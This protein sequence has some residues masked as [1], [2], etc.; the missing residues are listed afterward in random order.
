MIMFRLRRLALVLTIAFAALTAAS[1]IHTIAKGDSTM[2]LC[3][4]TA[5]TPLK[6]APS[7]EARAIFVLN[8]LQ[9]GDPTAAEIYISPTTCIQH[10]P[11]APDGREGVLAF[12]SNAT[13]LGATVNV[14]RVLV[15]GNFVALHSEYNFGGPM[16]GFDVFRFEDG[17]IVEHWD[18]LSP[19]TPPNPSKH[20]QTDG[21]VVVTDLDK[22]SQNCA[23]VVEFITKAL[24][25]PDPKLDITQYISPKTYIQHNPQVADGLAG[26]GEFMQSMAANKQV[27]SYSKIHFVVAQGNFV[28]VGSEGT[29][30]AAD[31]PTPTVY[32]DLFRLE[33]G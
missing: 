24:I 13:K 4:V 29:F 7:I 12:L 20:T 8:S 21:T 18:N 22:T 16:V 33:N 27:M 26:F 5:L 9:S 17:K 11:R 6:E 10:N 1:F 32:Y 19:K 25:T 23:K 3:D 14:K 30:G 28:L 15:S 2:S 31:K